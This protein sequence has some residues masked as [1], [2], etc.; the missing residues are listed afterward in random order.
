[1]DVGP[2][3]Q[4]APPPDSSPIAIAALPRKLQD[5]TDAVTPESQSAPPSAPPVYPSFG[6]ALF[7]SKAQAAKLA[8]LALSAATA[9]P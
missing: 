7:D 6:A 1:M 3:D 8:S 2:V 4:M 9:P 5:W